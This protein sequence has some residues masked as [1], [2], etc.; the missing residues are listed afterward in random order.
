MKIACAPSQVMRVG[1]D[2][3]QQGHAAW[4]EQAS[5]RSA[6]TFQDGVSAAIATAA[7]LS[8][9]V[10]QTSMVRRAF[11]FIEEKISFVAST[12]HAARGRPGKRQVLGS[13]RCCHLFF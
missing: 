13:G 5:S 7:R 1:R 8:P 6:V 3:N 9:A 11:A 4:Q 2:L 10:T 12:N